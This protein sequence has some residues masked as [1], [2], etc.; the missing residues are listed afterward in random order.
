MQEQNADRDLYQTGV[1]EMRAA[2]DIFKL[3]LWAMAFI[4]GLLL[5]LIF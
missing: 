4:V 3:V 2:L 5:G 1:D